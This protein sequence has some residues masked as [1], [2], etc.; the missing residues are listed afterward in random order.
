MTSRIPK[1][2][3]AVL[4]A[5]TA[6]APSAQAQEK[7]AP[8]SG[9]LLVSDPAG[10]AFVGFVGLVESP[11]PAGPNVDITGIFINSRDGR[12]TFNI[13]VAKL[14]KTVGQGATANVYRVN[15]DVGGA[16][17][18]LQATVNSA[19][20]A[21]SYG[22]SETSGLVKDGDAKGAFYEGESG[23]IE[24]EVPAT[25]GGKT[26]TKWSGASLFTAYVRG[27]AN[28]QTDEAPDAGGEFA[29]NGASCPSAEQPAPAPVPAPSPAPAP[30]PGPSPA[31]APA[32]PAQPSGPLKL[33][34]KPTTL[35]ASKV[36]KARRIAF[37]V[38]PSEKVTSLVATLKRGSK[39]LAK[40]GAAELQGQ[41]TL[42]FRLKRP[43]KKGR[44]TLLFT[45]KRSD[46][47]TGTVSIVVR[48]K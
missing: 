6:M 8:C 37:S 44:Y 20:V 4:L 46:G 36:R 29:Y 5:L 25:H 16:S 22:H 1:G 38:R 30:A 7:P 17:N 26:G 21:Y 28:T 9:K 14:D 34:V 41:R 13:Q 27:N 45:A 24:I 19:G 15:Y 42:T 40:T 2:A 10:D 47:S 18:Y 33:T 32:P 12:V 23:V 43:L 11:V 35:K 39:A 48:V 31:P 3:A